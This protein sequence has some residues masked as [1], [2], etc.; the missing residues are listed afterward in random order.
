M[1]DNAKF[2]GTE[3]SAAYPKR[4]KEDPV[5]DISVVIPCHN[6]EAAIADTLGNLQRVLDRHRLA[7]EIIVIDDGSTDGSAQALERVLEQMGP[8]IRVIRNEANLGYGASL[9]RGFR[10]ARA[11][12][13]CIIDADGTY[14]V[15]AV[16]G[17]VEMVAGGACDMAVA[18]RTGGNV[19]IPLIRRPAKWFLRKLANYVAGRA[20]P[21]INSGLRVFS[22]D[23]ANNM[24]GILPDG[25]SLTT[26]ITLAM[27]ANG[28]TVEY[29]PI[30]YA[31][32]LGKSKI[33]P[34][35][36]TLGFLQL[37]L[38]MA[39]YFAPL[40]VFIPLSFFLVLAAMAWGAFTLLAL[41][42][43]A[44]ITTLLLMM[45]GIQVGAIGLLAEMVRWR[46]PVTDYKT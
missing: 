9:K 25:F 5:L 6:E 1:D 18:S 43:L 3:Q 40:K 16:P 44:D 10:Y 34:I 30:D 33:H 2:A 42:Q 19:A 36:D 13:V 17:L 32:R 38:K 15:A 27:L 35:K 7:H 41:G 46:T 39:L 31:K 26:T 14:P 21:D 20:I 22:R 45:T 8:G 12:R 23:V 24:A 28:F 4:R 37:T 11:E 29:T